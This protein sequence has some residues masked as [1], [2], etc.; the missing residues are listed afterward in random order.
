MNPVLFLLLALACFPAYAEIYD[1]PV[2]MASGGVSG[3]VPV[4]IS[5][6]V[7]VGA[8]VQFVYKGTVS[9]D[10]HGFEFKGIPVGKYDILL[11][12]EPENNTRR[13]TLYSG[14]AVTAGTAEVPAK[15]A[16]GL[17]KRMELNDKFFSRFKLAGFSFIDGNSIGL[18]VVERIKESPITHMNGTV[19]AHY[20]RRVEIA[21]VELAV[22]DWKTNATRHVY[23]VEMPMEA[24]KPFLEY[25]Q[26]PALGKIRVVDAVKDLGLINLP[27]STSGGST[28]KE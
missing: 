5:D 9:P 12:D 26:I 28:P 3:T 24:G 11:F 22:D 23:R 14:L 15:F 16:A 27:A 18:A 20:L 8:N 7:L 4:P 2:D 19:Q 6:A 1:A 13:G 25:V 10:K 21:T 17:M